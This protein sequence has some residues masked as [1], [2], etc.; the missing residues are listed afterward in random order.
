MKILEHMTNDKGAVYLKIRDYGPKNYDSHRGYS[1]NLSKYF[2]YIH[3]VNFPFDPN[4]RFHIMAEFSHRDA[5]VV[6]W[7]YHVAPFGHAGNTT[8]LSSYEFEC[9]IIGE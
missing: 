9:E 8:D 5:I 2:R 1:L 4:N 6:F 3:T 7:F